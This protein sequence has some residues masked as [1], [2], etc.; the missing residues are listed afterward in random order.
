[1]LSAG[2]NSVYFRL[3][4]V[5]TLCVGKKYLITFTLA[6]ETRAYTYAPIGLYTVIWNVPFTAMPVL[7][8]FN[9]RLRSSRNTRSD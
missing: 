2:P 4:I 3:C 6:V 8:F 7:I 5:Y 1:M 9:L